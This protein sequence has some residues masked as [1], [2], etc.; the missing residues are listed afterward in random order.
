M[1][2]RWTVIILVSILISCSN[3]STH[4]KTLHSVNTIATPQAKTQLNFVGHWLYQ[5]KREDLVREIANEF[6][7]L[8]QNCKVNLKFPEEIY[9]SRDKADCEEEFVSKQ[10]LSDK[11]T[12]DI[13]RIN[14][15]Y[16]KIALYMKD[17]DWPKKYLVDFSQYSEFIKN[18]LPNLVNDEAKAKWKGI[19]PGPSLEG[20]N[21]SIWYNK[22]LAKEMGI[23]IKQFGMTF[24]DLLQYIKS[25]DT[26]NKSH[27]TNITPIQECGDWSTINIIG[28]RLYLS[29]LGD[30]EEGLKDSYNEKK[31]SAFYKTLQAFE[32]LSK[33]NAYSKSWKDNTFMKTVDFPLTHKCFFYVN[34]SWMYNYWQKVDN[35]QLVNMIPCELPVFKPCDVYFGGYSVMWAVPKNAPHKE[36]AIKF[37]LFMTNP[38]VAE[39]WNRYT[40]CPTGLKGNITSVSLGNDHFEEFTSTINSK[41]GSRKLSFNI[42]DNNLVLGISRQN[43][44]LHSIDVA[45]GIMTA[46]EG[47][48]DIRKQLKN[49]KQ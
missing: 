5:A 2:A 38:D 37:I 42:L 3:N 25:I 7:F 28:L 22:A 29:E 10:L 41:Y 30:L 17:M 4:E 32:E 9:Y 12:F 6:E 40:K 47:I 14:D 35:G 1:K 11:P 23:E 36:E 31:L 39:K 16:L 48:A 44:K 8:N 45:T 33:Y 13:L 21:Y 49:Y 43:V 19:I 27:K 46:D 26:Y 24:N 18:T 15:A 20:Y 34:A